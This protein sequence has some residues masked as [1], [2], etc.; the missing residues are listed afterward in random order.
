MS[1]PK[2]YNPS[3]REEPRHQLAGIIPLQQEPSI[4]DWL[5]STGRLLAR[6][7]VEDTFMDEDEEIADLMTVDDGAYDDLDDDD[8]VVEVED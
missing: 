5:E 2:F 4:L 3:L 6:E 1:D 8:D 7:V